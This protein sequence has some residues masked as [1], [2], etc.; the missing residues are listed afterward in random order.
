MSGEFS[1]VTGQAEESSDAGDGAR[2]R[3]VEAVAADDVAEVVDLFLEKLAFLQFHPK[4]C[5]P[6]ERTCRVRPTISS[7]ESPQMRPLS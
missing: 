2:L 7:C 4:T 6:E 5:F 3:K 1:V